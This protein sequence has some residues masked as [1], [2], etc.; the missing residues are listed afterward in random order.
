[1]IYTNR[2]IVLYCIIFTIM[3]CINF[4]IICCILPC[5]CKINFHSFIHFHCSYN[6]TLECAANAKI[7]DWET[8]G[9]YSGSS[10][11]TLFNLSFSFTAIDPNHTMIENVRTLSI[12]AVSKVSMIGVV[13][14]NELS[15]LR[16]YSRCCAF[17]TIIL[18]LG[19]L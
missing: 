8:S 14:P 2:G 17:L 9:Y 11:T 13:K 10:F 16:R 19:S 5:C 18:I 3:Y 7:Q 15:L 1:M 6:K 12:V 4:P